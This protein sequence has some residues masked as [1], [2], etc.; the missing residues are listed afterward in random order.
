MDIESTLSGHNLAFLEALYEA[1]QRD[2]NSVDPEWVPVLRDL[3]RT[4]QGE[5]AGAPTPSPGGA[6]R[7][8]IRPAEPPPASS[9]RTSACARST[10]TAGST[11][12]C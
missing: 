3:E 11:P 9:P 4:N 5:R 2:P 1:Y 7:S 6:Q 12:A 8:S 10:W